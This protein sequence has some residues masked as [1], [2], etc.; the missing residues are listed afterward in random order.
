MHIPSLSPEYR[1]QRRLDYLLEGW[2]DRCM[3]NEWMEVWRIVG[4]MQG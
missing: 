4:W 2:I 3:E 1:G